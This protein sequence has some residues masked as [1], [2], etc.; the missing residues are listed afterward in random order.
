[1]FEEALNEL[2]LLSIYN[3]AQGLQNN[4]KIEMDLNVYE[5]LL[6]HVSDCL[7][8][9][10]NSTIIALSHM[11]YGWMPTMLKKTNTNIDAAN[12]ILRIQNSELSEDLV[13]SVKS[14]TNNSVVGA[15]KLLHFINPNSYAIFDS[16][17]YR[18][19]ANGLTTDANNCNK[20]IAYNNK[21]HNLIETNENNLV[22]Q[23][24]RILIDKNYIRNNY[25]NYRA[26]EI[27]LYEN[28]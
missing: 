19:I 18:S 21:L 5:A 7:L 17:V 13:N 12:F 9:V 20:Y 26:I 4:E 22:E 14:I 2:S 8:N 28:D 23:I 27:C 25:S 10:N 16:R 3:M 11:V 6:S 24:R 1:M 15:S